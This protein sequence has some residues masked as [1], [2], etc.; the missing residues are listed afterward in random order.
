M[1]YSSSC[2]ALSFRKTDKG[3]VH[4]LPQPATTWG[5]PKGLIVMPAVRAEGQ[6]VNLKSGLA[7][8]SSQSWSISGALLTPLRYKSCSFGDDTVPTTVPSPAVSVPVSCTNAAGSNLL[9]L[10]GAPVL[11][12]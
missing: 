6:T 1:A 10:T 3:T 9:Q 11:R 2:R 4:S 12:S 8:T 5:K 7:N